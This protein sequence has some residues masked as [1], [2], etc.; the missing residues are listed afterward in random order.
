MSDQDVR[1]AVEAGRTSQVYGPLHSEGIIPASASTVLS[2]AHRTWNRPEAGELAK[3]C[4]LATPNCVAVIESYQKG[5]GSREAGSI[6][7]GE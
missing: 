5:P 7:P 3:L 4:A 2:E 6:E 1:S